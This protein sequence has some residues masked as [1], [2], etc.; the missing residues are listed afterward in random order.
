MGDVFRRY[1][2]DLAKATTPQPA[3][4]ENVVDYTGKLTAAPGGGA[5]APGDKVSGGVAGRGQG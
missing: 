4:G 3:R 2:D 1:H 5:A